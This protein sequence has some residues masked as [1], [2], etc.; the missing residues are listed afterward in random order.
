MPVG[1]N[2]DP[3]AVA[4]VPR[5]LSEHPRR[6]FF[7]STAWIALAVAPMAL[8]LTWVVGIIAYRGESPL[9]RWVA[10]GVAIVF[11]TLGV[12]LSASGVRGATRSWRARLGRRLHPDQPWCWDH[13]WKR[14]GVDDDSPLRATRVI[15]VA[16]YVVGVLLSLNAVVFCVNGMTWLGW[17]VVVALNLAGLGMVVRAIIYLIRWIRLGRGRLTFATFPFYLGERLAASLIVPGSDSST[18]SFRATLRCIEERWATRSEGSS[19]RYAVVSYEI[20]SAQQTPDAAVGQGSRGWPF[21]FALPRHLPPTRLSER[22][23]RYWQLDIDGQAAGTAHRAT[24]LVPVYE[25]NVKS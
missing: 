20:Y 17:M 2:Q 13:S 21:A 25:P 6:T 24:F 10:T 16:L 9:E 22:P 8:V 4:P 15:F 12:E 1:E 19:S 11:G 3:A 5:P 18:V 7:P 23:A 14:H